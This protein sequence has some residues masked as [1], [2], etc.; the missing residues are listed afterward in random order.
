MIKQ[1]VRSEHVPVP[2]ASEAYAKI[3][4]IKCYMEIILVQSSDLLVKVFANCEAGPCYCRHILRH[5][6]SMHVAGSVSVKIAVNV[7]RYTTNPEYNPGVLYHSVW[8]EKLRANCTDF[9]PQGQTYH[10]S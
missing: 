1:R 6:R 7:A 10:F 2:F 4:I 5:Y 3:D 8:I 9:W